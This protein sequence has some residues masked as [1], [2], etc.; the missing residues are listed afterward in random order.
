MKVRRR[1]RN[2]KTLPLFRVGFE[3]LQNCLK[4]EAKKS[5]QA[6]HNGTDDDWLFN[7]GTSCFMI[8]REV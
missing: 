7:D 2:T 8:K 6:I 4:T 5:F 1:N 3:T